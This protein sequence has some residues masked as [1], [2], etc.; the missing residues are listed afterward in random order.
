MNSSNNYKYITG[1]ATTTVAGLETKRVIIE[2]IQINKTMTGTLIIKASGGSGTTIGVIAAT[3]IPGTYWQ[4]A[5]GIEV[6][7]PAFIN[8]SSE[9]ITIFWRNA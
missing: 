4:T 7:N 9:D 1:A 8:G 2:C 6:E 3:T 5:S